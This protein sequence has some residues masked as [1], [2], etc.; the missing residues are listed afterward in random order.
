MAVLNLGVKVGGT[1]STVERETAKNFQLM[2][3][4]ETI[5]VCDPCRL[6]LDKH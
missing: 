3:E 4:R 5:S 6:R 1:G 2:V